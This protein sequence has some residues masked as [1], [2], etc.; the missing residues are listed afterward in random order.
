MS[1]VVVGL[2]TE[3][4]G[5]RGGGG[6]RGL[7][8][9]GGGGGGRDAPAAP[10]GAQKRT[11][12]GTRIRTGR[13]RPPGGAA[14]CTARARA[15]SARP[16]VILAR[17]QSAALILRFN[18]GRCTPEIGAQIHPDRGR[19]GPRQFDRQ[20]PPSPS[21]V[22]VPVPSTL[23]DGASRAPTGA[24]WRLPAVVPIVVVAL[25]AANGMV[26]STTTLQG[27]R[28]HAAHQ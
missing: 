7:A 23:C 27:S 9:G 10:T 20:P 11:P 15:S 14:A 19:H 1:A 8:W 21:R 22:F 24:P 3:R 12:A 16:A 17:S 18:R 2:T 13:T 5:G 25:T 28:F 4:G 6:D 26:S